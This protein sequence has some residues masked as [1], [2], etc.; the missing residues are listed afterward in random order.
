[1]KML[2]AIHKAP[3]NWHVSQKRRKRGSTFIV[4]LKRN[5]ER[6]RLQL[7]SRCIVNNI[8]AAAFELMALLGAINRI[9][10]F[11]FSLLSEQTVWFLPIQQTRWTSFFFFLYIVVKQLS[12]AL[13]VWLTA[14]KLKETWIFFLFGVFFHKCFDITVMVH[15]TKSKNVK[16]R[17]CF[18]RFD[19]MR[20]GW[21]MLNKSN[22]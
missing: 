18:D 15:F 21:P 9:F 6:F 13:T 14:R 20:V 2:C 7:H 19:R 11:L 5:I 17:A 10:I 22:Y 16:R 12:I 3:L 1:M 4:T 8:Q